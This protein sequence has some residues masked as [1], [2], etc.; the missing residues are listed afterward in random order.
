MLTRIPINYLSRIIN[1][2]FFGFSITFDRVLGAVSVSLA[3]W[4]FAAYSRQLKI[5]IKWFITFMIVMF[6]LNKWE[7]LTNGSG[8]SHFFAFACFYYHQ[9]LFDRYYRGQERK[10]DKTILM[11]LPWLIILGTAGPYCAIYAVVMILASGAAAFMDTGEKTKTVCDLS[12][13]HTD[14]AAP[15][16]SQQFLCSRRTCRGNRKILRGNIKRL[17]YISHP[18]YP[19]IPGRNDG[20]R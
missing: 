9:I 3:A 19:E 5:N 8:W 15:L 4:C 12:Y 17:P 16:H 11:L 7:M 2:K 6:S 10:W 20:W 14:P 18:F 13:L 1:V